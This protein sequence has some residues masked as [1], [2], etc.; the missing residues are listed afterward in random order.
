[1]TTNDRII[2]D[3]ILEQKHHELGPTLSPTKF[4]ELF[5]AGEIVKDYDLSYDELESGIVGDGGDGG[6]DAIYLFAN[7]ELVQDDTDLSA[8]K[9]NV[10]IELYLI[11]SKTSA[12]FTETA[13]EKLKAFTEDLLN[14]SKDVNSL[15]SVYNDDVIAIVRR[16]RSSYEA[17]AS[18]FPALSVK[19]RYA[20]KGDQVH[21]NVQRKAELVKDV[22]RQ[23][24]SSAQVDFEFLGARELLLLARR[25]PRATYSLRLAENPISSSG[26]V[27][28]VCLVSLK[29]YHSFIVDENGSLIRSIFES[30]VRDY[31]GATQ[32]NDQIQ[33]TLKEKSAEEFWWLNNGITIVAVNA[34][35]SGKTLTIED[36]QIVNGLQTSTVIFGH[37]K[38]NNTENESRNLLVRVIVPPVAESRDRIIK[39]TNSQTAIPIASLRATEAIHRDIEEYLLP[40][41]LFYDRRKNHYKNEARPIERIVSIP[42]LAQAVMAIALRRPNDAR[43]RPS[44]LLKRDEEYEQVFSRDYPIGLYLNCALLMKR[45]DQVVRSDAAGLDTKD[46]TNIRF[47]VGMAAACTAIGKVNPTPQ[48]VS[49]VAVNS[50]ADDTIETAMRRVFELYQKLGGTDQT[51]KGTELVTSLKHD[52]ASLL[53]G[54]Q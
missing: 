44:S 31:Q 34:T 29:D 53:H 50:I 12:T 11:Q 5:A 24:F 14:L 10:A 27:A 45:V 32:V 7:G 35:L 26:A 47:Y 41:G 9:R 30:N 36:P 2:L 15:L 8:L 28:F 20:S 40:H 54:S 37:F 16:F 25:A 46:Q 49:L 39:A 4:F 6:V 22:V 51:A 19:Y 21:P 17:L 42:H 48:D 1:M 13:I 33:T 38:E 23:L 52:L 43:A 3:K 18:R